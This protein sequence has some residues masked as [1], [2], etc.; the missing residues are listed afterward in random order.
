M[1]FGIRKRDAKTGNKRERV[2][3]RL[4]AEQVRAGEWARGAGGSAYHFFID[5]ASACGRLRVFTGLRESNVRAL[6]P[7][8]FAAVSRSNAQADMLTGL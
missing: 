2:I 3:A 4:S 1:D 6:C 5:N 8:C 7:E